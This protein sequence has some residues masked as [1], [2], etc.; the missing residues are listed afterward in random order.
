[1]LGCFGGPT[2]LR[3]SKLTDYGIV[4]LATLAEAGHGATHNARELAEATALP[5][6][7]VSKIL[8]SLA[9][10]G[11]LHSHRG[12]KGGYGL[13]RSPEAIR[14]SD[15][16][17]ALEGPIALMACSAGPGRCEQESRCRVRHP[18]QRIHQT[19]HQALEQV[20]LAQLVQPAD[21]ALPSL[22][23]TAARAAERA[24]GAGGTHV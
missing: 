8:K 7:M 14:V 3:I 10:E 11:F 1:M 15:I 18:W 9:Q 16:I 13:A 2:M 19:I 4:L 21:E 17:A 22:A 24:R 20:T 23:P 12:S 6:P 5:L